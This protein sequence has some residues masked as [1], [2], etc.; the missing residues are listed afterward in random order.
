[1]AARAK[2]RRAVGVDIGGTGMK[3]GV[4]DLATGELVTDRVRIPTP[5]NGGPDD[6]GP[7]VGQLMAL[8]GDEAAGLPI[9][10]GFPGP[11]VGGRIRTA[12]NLGPGWKDVDGAQVF[13]RFAGAP[14][15]MCN[16]ADAAGVAEM[17]FGAAR[18]EGGVVLVL[19]IG[20]GIGSAVFTEGRLVPNTELG[21]LMVGSREAEAR[22]SASARERE[23]LSW[24]KW[25]KQLARVIS[26]YNALLWPDLVVLGGGVSK[27]SHDWL[28]HVQ[29]EVEVPLRVATL[30]NRAG[31]VGAAMIAVEGVG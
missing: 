18:G 25:A 20:T 28:P 3:A 13:G 22:A 11:I 9:G 6:L 2:A 31:V 26:T 8:L 21:H 17:R 5:A 24:R 7:V 19:T 15:V 30:Q 16:D 12:A 29:E 4:V 14:V 27:R 1:M 10:I 23:G